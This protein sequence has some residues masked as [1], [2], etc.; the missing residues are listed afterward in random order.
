MT[1]PESNRRQLLKW[2]ACAPLMV[3]GTAVPSLASVVL[4]ASAASVAFGAPGALRASERARA[5]TPDASYIKLLRQGGCVVLIRHSMTVS[6]I[7][8]PPGMRLDDCSTQRDLSAEGRAQA[9]RVGQWFKQHQLVPSAVRSSQWCRCLNTAKEA[10]SKNNFGQDIPVQ[11]W[12]ALNSFF[13]GHGN[14]DQQLQEA[15]AAAR[16]LAITKRAGQFE[17][18][19][20]HQVVVST[21]TGTYLAMGEM[22]VAQ[23][24]VVGQVVGQGAA[25]E[26]ASLTPI[27]TL[28]KGLSI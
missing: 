24:Q 19:V 1:V 18:W 11:P 16:T 28:A 14:R 22:I 23:G 12:V 25:A 7:G 6:G 27:R 20:T 5:D 13:Q 17:V 26:A 2:G 15:A 10:F 21:L 3:A 4:V 9:R 8:D